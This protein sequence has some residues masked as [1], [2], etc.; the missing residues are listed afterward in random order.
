MAAVSSSEEIE[1]AGL[2]A[3]T[4]LLIAAV[5][6]QQAQCLPLALH[7]V[8]VNIPH[9]HPGISMMRFNLRLDTTENPELAQPELRGLDL[10][11]AQPAVLFE[12]DKTPEKA[13][14]QTT[15]PTCSSPTC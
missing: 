15:A 11:P 5:P 4:E 13:S 6:Q 1:G 12:P 8:E 14:S 3:N 2:H 7:H 9:G 10:R